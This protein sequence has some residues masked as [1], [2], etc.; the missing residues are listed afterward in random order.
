MP[1]PT[2]TD[3]FKILRSEIQ[4]IKSDFS[5]NRIRLR[6][7]EDG[8]KV[9]KTDQSDLNKKFD[10]TDQKLSTWKSQLFDKIDKFLG[11]ISKQDQEIIFQTGRL[12]SHEGD[13]K[14]LK[15]KVFSSPN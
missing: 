15:S 8:I 6:T 3:Q 13:I 9:I 7:I 14:K 10:D 5:F 4:E 12:D 1:K 11:R 2:K